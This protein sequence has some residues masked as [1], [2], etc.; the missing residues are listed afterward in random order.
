[1][2]IGTVSRF[3]LAV[4]TTLSLARPAAAQQY[5]LGGTA[6]LGS[7]LV[8]GGS[9]S[10]IIERARTRLRLALDLRVDEF[11]K[12]IFAI[13]MV[14]EIEPHSSFGID[15]RYLRKVSAKVDV[16]AGAVGFIYPQS[17]VGPSA[18]LDYH[19]KLSEGLDVV[20]GP[21][22]DVFIIGTDLPSNS[23]LWQ[24]LLQAGIHVDL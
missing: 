21:E 3:A 22:L 5:L 8:G 16:N 20:I 18:G 4:A 15:L 2:N 19:L 11:P 1:M 23:V 9:G 12:D 17:L 6:E 7:G 13:G 14:A 24:A 10:A